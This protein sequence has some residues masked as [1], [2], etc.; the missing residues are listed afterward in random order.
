MAQSKNRTGGIVEYLV[1]AFVLATTLL[2]L[3][4]IGGN[5]S[6]E[7]EYREAIDAPQVHPTETV[8][9]TPKRLQRY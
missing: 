9:L 7:L 5:V 8:T 1:M 6:N 2:V 3:A 4:E